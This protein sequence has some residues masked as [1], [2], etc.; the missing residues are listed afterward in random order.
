[1]NVC[2]CNNKTKKLDKLILSIIK[3]QIVVIFDYFILWEYNLL[4][5]SNSIFSNKYLLDLVICG[6]FPIKLSESINFDSI[7]YFYILLFLYS[8]RFNYSLTLFKTSMDFYFK[9]N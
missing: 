7:D 9:N 6:K 8:S 2:R 3:N 5:Y 4:Y 1:M